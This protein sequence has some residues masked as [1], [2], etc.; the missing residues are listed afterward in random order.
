M[1][2]KLFF[3]LIGLGL[4][5]LSACAPRVDY[6]GQI[7]QLNAQVNSLRTENV[8][9]KAET[10]AL[11]LDAQKWQQVLATFTDQPYDPPLP[12]HIW[13]LLPDGKQIF[14]HLDKEV[15]KAE[16]IIYTGIAVPGK[17]CKEDQEKL[18]K[19]FT[20]FH[21]EKAPSVEEGHAGTFPGEEGFWLMHIALGEFDMPWG[22][23]VPGVDEKFMPTEPPVCG[24]K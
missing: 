8:A 16:K 10:N 20:H 11:K 9:V 12:D 6:E 23:V 1:T 17:W 13:K 7:T 4:L 14:F 19:G 15:P 21:R 5:V 3:F 18:P 24:K 2:N 22:H